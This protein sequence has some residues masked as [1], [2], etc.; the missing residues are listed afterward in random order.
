M[1]GRSPLDVDQAQAQLALALEL[2]P[3]G[4]PERASL[5]ESWAQAAHQQGRL[6]EARQALEEALALHRG[7]SDPVAAGRVLTALSLVLFRLGDRQSDGMIAEAV[8]LLETQPAGPELVVAHTLPGRRRA[9]VATPP[10]GGRGRRAGTRAR[11]ELSLPEP[12]RA[13]RWRGVARSTWAKRTASTTCVGRS[14]LA[15]EQGLGR[16]TAVIHY[17][18]ADVVLSV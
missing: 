9:L 18:L 5:L 13:L 12:A 15:L 8:E 6:Q 14:H 17:N 16:E 10:G 2:A 11:R 1:S 7:R 4:H 3:A